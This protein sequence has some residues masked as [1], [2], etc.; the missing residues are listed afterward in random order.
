MPSLNDFIDQKFARINHRRTVRL[1]LSQG[2]GGQADYMTINRQQ[3]ACTALY[4]AVVIPSGARPQFNF[5][6][7][8]Q[9]RVTEFDRCLGLVGEM[10]QTASPHIGETATFGSHYEDCFGTKAWHGSSATKRAAI[11]RNAQNPQSGFESRVAYVRTK[12]QDL[13]AAYAQPWLLVASTTRGDAAALAGLDSH[14]IKIGPGFPRGAPAHF[15]AGVLIHEMGHNLGLADVCSVCHHTQ[16]N[17]ST[18]FVDRGRLGCD[19]GLNGDHGDT[20]PAG[21]GHY[22]GSA[23]VRSLA[24]NHKNMSVFNTDSYRWFCYAYWKAEITAQA[25]LHERLRAAEG[26]APRQGPQAWAR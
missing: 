20:G 21:T 3:D 19:A 4:D 25:A 24:S 6:G 15:H 2:H 8:T 12:F 23:R 1:F 9:A 7:F 18:H 5:V 10:L 11:A 26:P 14:E 16:L 22:I 13:I 17:D